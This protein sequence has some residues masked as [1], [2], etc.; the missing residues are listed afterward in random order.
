MI[1][2]KIGSYTVTLI[3]ASI[4]SLILLCGCGRLDINL[5]TNV[6]A[7][8]D[9]IQEVVTTGSGKMAEYLRNSYNAQ[10]DSKE[11][12]QANIQENADSV[13]VT[14]KRVFKPGETTLLPTTSTKTL[15]G[16]DFHIDN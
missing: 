15:T 9:V 2:G 12:W 3:V 5:R 1:K 13:T 16:V 14:Q 4:I 7:Q 10:G 6:T 11:G 8:G